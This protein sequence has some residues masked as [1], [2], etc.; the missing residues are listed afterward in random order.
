MMSGTYRAPDMSFWA[1]EVFL[2]CL[3]DSNVREYRGYDSPLYLK[4]NSEEDGD[5]E[6]QH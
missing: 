1:R 3:H 5:A 4:S 6:A 2:F